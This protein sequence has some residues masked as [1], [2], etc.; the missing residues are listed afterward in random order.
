MVIF[1][2]LVLNEEGSPDTTWWNDNGAPAGYIDF[3]KVNASEWFAS[4][5][6][7]LMI[8]YDIDSFK[9][10]AGES[11][12]TPQVIYKTISFVL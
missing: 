2:Y 5:V 8:N 4:R 9:F 11:S 6:R 12:F 3:T 10:D 1:R 7:N